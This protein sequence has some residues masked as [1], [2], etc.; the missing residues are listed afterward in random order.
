LQPAAIGNTEVGCRKT[1]HLANGFCHG[2]DFFIA[3][4]TGIDAGKIPERA[5]MRAE[6]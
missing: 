2:Y 6:L 3:D 4:I 5:R 1:G